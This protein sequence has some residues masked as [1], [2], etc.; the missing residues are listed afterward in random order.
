MCDLTYKSPKEDKS[1]CR[2]MLWFPV[3]L[4]W[5]SN[6]SHVI[7]LSSSTWFHFHSMDILL[8]VTEKAQ[9]TAITHYSS[10]GMSSVRRLSVL[11]S[12]SE[13]MSVS[14]RA[15]AAE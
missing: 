8:G 5:D 14:L 6:H 4:G 2:K 15:I 3:M 9:A 11:R 7:G 13:D 1:H 12:D 10:D